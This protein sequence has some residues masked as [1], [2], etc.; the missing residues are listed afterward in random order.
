MELSGGKPRNPVLIFFWGLGL[1]IIMQII[2]GVGIAAVISL[3]GGQTGASARMNFSNPLA[4]F[5]I[6]I[7]ALVVGLPL[8]LLIIRFLWRRGNS[9][10]GMSFNF[11]LFG[12]G[13]AIGIGLP[14]IIILILAIWGT[15]NVTGYPGRFDIGQIAESLVGYFLFMTLIGVMEEFYFR[16]VL[17]REW[18]AKW[19]WIAASV[20]SGLIFGAAHILNLKHAT[21]SIGIR[22]MLAGM[23]IG[24]LL[25]AL[26]YRTGSLWTAIGFHAGWNFSLSALLGTTVSGLPSNLGLF[27]IELEGP[28]LLTGGVFGL[29]V[30]AVTFIVVILATLAVL[31]YMKMRQPSAFQENPGSVI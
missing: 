6:G 15:V 1:F 23:L 25:I 10:I 7:Y 20:L 16:G 24:F 21:F 2:L 31:R 5:L 14:V 22:I 12:Y 26:Y 27:R 4:V 13:T 28:S 11:R 3:T 9:W 17:T 19:G 8:S 30:S 29:E 18:A